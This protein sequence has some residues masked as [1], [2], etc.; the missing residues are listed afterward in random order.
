MHRAGNTSHWSNQVTKIGEN[1]RP[2]HNGNE[3][4]GE[5]AASRKL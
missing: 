1:H 3:K 5:Q 4:R 2:S